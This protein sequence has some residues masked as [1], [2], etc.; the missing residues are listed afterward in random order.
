MRE[1]IF[2]SRLSHDLEN[3]V[4]EILLDRIEPVWGSNFSKNLPSPTNTISG[5]HQSKAVVRLRVTRKIL[6]LLH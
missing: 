1:E 6:L 5:G 3:N 4:D 2:P